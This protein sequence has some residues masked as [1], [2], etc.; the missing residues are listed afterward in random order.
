MALQP[1]THA[2]GRL[3]SCWR[4]R[5]QVVEREREGCGDRTVHD[6]AIG[7]VGRRDLNARPGRGHVDWQALWSH[8]WIAGRE[9][10]ERR[11]G[12]E[13]L[14]DGRESERASGRRKSHPIHKRFGG[15]KISY[16]AMRSSTG[17]ARSG[18]LRI[19]AVAEMLGIPVPTIRSW[20]RR[21]G[22]PQPARTG[23]KHRRYS[24]DELAQL[25]GVRDRITRGERTG[26][27][28]AAVQAAGTPPPLHRGLLDAFSAAAD[29][30]DL[31]ALRNV[32]RSA[33]ETLGAD[34][35]IAEIALPGMR[36]VGS[37][38]RAGETDVANE[39]AATQVTRQWLAWMAAFMPP[40]YRRHPI[41]LAC[42]PGEQHTVGL[43]AF[44]VMLARRG[45]TTR[46]LGADTPIPSVAAAVRATAAT[47]VVVTAQRRVTRRSA[48]ATVT[49]ID[50]L[51]RVTA[52]YAGN[53]FVTARSRSGVPGVYLGEDMIAAVDVVE[54]A[55]GR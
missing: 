39:H 21:Y 45:W 51:P 53:A 42:A 38:W 31:E 20:E 12:A 4:E 32:L 3:A 9:D 15:C 33:T 2:I 5:A 16:A 37:R 49:T 1:S 47:G 24:A 29:S 7:G 35:A 55:V 46:L 26:D 17:A 8:P 43:E 34:R 6:E 41:V 44:A 14:T 52:F 23:G 10:R 40:P 25:R 13:R 22:F 36:A 48:I 18:E 27:A 28:I 50:R 11:Q 54:A 19:S 30:M